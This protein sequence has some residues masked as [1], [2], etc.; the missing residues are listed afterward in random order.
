MN[1]VLNYNKNFEIITEKITIEEY[2][3]SENDN[4]SGKKSPKPSDTISFHH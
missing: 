2:L 3:T 4:A 1:P